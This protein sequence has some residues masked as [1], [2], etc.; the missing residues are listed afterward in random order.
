MKRLFGKNLWFVS[1]IEDSDHICNTNKLCE[2][3]RTNAE[4]DGG[5][6]YRK[7]MQVQGILKIKS[8]RI[9]LRYALCE[10]PIEEN[11]QRSIFDLLNRL[12]RSLNAHHL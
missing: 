4:E 10:N 2:V 8:W 7:Q 11:P 12:R 9:S 3:E 6:L 1:S 5:L